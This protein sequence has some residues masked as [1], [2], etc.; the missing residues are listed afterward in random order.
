[1]RHVIS[2]IVVAY[3][4]LFYAYSQPSQ[5][6][7][8]NRKAIRL[9]EEANGQFRIR[10]FEAGMNLLLQA[11]RKDPSFAEAHLQLAHNYQMFGYYENALHH[12]EMA[13]KASPGSPRVVGAY[14]TLA[15]ELLKLGRYSEA[16]E[17]ALRFLSF[18]P[19]SSAYSRDM[20]RVVA[21]AE[22][23]QQAMENPL[24]FTPK[25]LPGKVN[26]KQYLQYFPVLTADE[27]TLI[28]TARLKEQGKDEDIFV[29]YRQP[30]GTWGDPMP[31]SPVINT[32]NSEGTCA[33]SADG[34]VLVFTS[35][36][37][38][39][40]YGS[41]DLFVSYRYGNEWTTPV[42]LGANV[43]SSSWES[44][45][46]LSPDGR[47]L[48]FVSD[49]PGG[50]GERD[51]YMT[52]RDEDGRWLPAVN[53]GP[54]INTPG[55]E[56]S[57]FLFANGR[58]LYF[59][60]NGH[61]GMG[62]FDLYYSDW[63]R[64]QWSQPINLGYPINDHRSQVSL[65]I[66]ASQKQGYYAHEEWQGKRQLSATLMY[67]DM[68]ETLLPKEQLAYVQG[69]VRDAKSGTPLQATIELLSIDDDSLVARVQSDPV[70]GS[71][72]ILLTEGADYALS[73]NKTGYLMKTYP[74]R[75][76]QLDNTS[77]LQI[78]IELDPIEVGASFVLTNIFFEYG[79]YELR[80]ES[81]TELNKLIAFMQANPGMIA[82]IAGHTDDIGDEKA[83]M[84]LSLRRAKAVYDYLVANGIDSRRLRYKGYGEQQPAVP[85]DSEENRAKNRRIEFR[86]LSVGNEKP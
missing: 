37:S 43:N 48:F 7:T 52:T 20:E 84:E 1:M 51:I 59:A 69:V 45:P 8:Q 21:S 61:V 15:N 41:C 67:F 3:C 40:G 22:F 2:G 33:I 6:S 77:M 9:Y 74:F 78:D 83:N 29:S 65:F 44:Q 47:V 24:P 4:M 70:T 27:Q 86:V 30:D 14:Y 68:P 79:K 23:A 76:K 28:F 50:L 16:R 12:Y 55:D 38:R 11:V 26:R 63:Q 64:G 72:L 58:R 17:Y 54:P 75:L 34:S 85:N 53:L 39:L 57:P 35:C 10:N 36:Q 42:N 56:V 46:T 13:V 49:R 25:P 62:D 19:E 32:P 5:Y 66:T 71:Y 82:E 81:R 73:A 31:I 80:S 60:S 18:Q